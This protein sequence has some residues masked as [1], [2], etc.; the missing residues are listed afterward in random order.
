M[1][2]M[3]IQPSVE[4]MPLAVLSVDNLLT[5]YG[6]T[7][8]FW[9]VT[10][11]KSTKSGFPEEIIVKDVRMRDLYSNTNAFNSTNYFINI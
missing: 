1:E 5:E 8:V 10:F 4:E 9:M 3:M 2:I 7:G 11:A 6:A